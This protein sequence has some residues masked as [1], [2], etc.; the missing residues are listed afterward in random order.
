MGEYGF[1]AARRG[2][3]N[4]ADPPRGGACFTP[5]LISGALG[6]R[7]TPE[8]PAGEG[9][10]RL[11]GGYWWQP[12]PIQRYLPAEGFYLLQAE[13]NP[14]GGQTGYTYDAGHVLGGVND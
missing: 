13:E 14:D 9:R 10:Y 12:G 1:A 11:D 7:V 8:Q 5:E 6:D 2:W 3:Q 4:H